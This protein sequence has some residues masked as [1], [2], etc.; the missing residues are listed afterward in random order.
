MK[1]L[2]AAALALLVF[3]PVARADDESVTSGSVTATLSWSGDSFDTQG[4][5]LTITGGGAVAF[6]Q[7]VPK[8]VCDGCVL[9]GSGADDIRIN[10]LDGD[11]EVEA[12]DRA[13]TGG[14]GGCINPGGGDFGPA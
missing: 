7:A 14:A 12:T 9:V 4:A 6:S 3:V 5:K 8:V 2:L 1:T 13:S 11:G 10:D